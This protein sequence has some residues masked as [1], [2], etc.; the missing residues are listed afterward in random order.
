YNA[1]MVEH[2]DRFP[3]VR[4][5]SIFVGN[6]DDI[7][8]DRLGPDLPGIREW[9]TAHFVFP[10]YVTGFDPG[11]FADR[12]A[13]RRELGYGPDER[14]VLVTVGGSGTGEHLLRRIIAAHPHAR[15]LI[16]E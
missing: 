15:R 8:P 5:R 14:V 10:G 2:I 16:P 13:L 7:V 1:E 6:P 9:T 11:A 4:D 3:S 12:E